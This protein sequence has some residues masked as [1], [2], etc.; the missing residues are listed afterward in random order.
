MILRK[1]F[2]LL[3]LASFAGCSPLSESQMTGLQVEVATTDIPSRTETGTPAVATYCTGPIVTLSGVTTDRYTQE[4]VSDGTLFDR[5]NWYSNAVGNGTNTAFFVGQ[6]N[7]PSKAICLLG[8]V[9]NGHIPLDWSWREVHEFGGSGDRMYSSGL[10][11]VDSARVHNVE[12]GWKPRELPEFGNTGSIYM[13]NTYM[14]GIRDDS[15]EDD[16]FMPGIIED[17]LFDGVHTFLSE[18]NQSGKMPSTI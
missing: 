9:I 4:L 11:F 12:D 17:S 15:I 14:T 8:G 10:V 16:N 7:Q 18:Q 6:S 1:F 5:T 3:L 2:S 13:R